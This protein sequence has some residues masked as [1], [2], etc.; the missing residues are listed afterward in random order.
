MLQRANI[1][2]LYI[3]YLNPNLGRTSVPSML[4]SSYAKI[5][6]LVKSSRNLGRRYWTMATLPASLE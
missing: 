6:R 3:E 2:L 4:A 1:P 5:L